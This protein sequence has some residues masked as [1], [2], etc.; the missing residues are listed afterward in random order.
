MIASYHSGARLAGGL[1]TI[2]NGSREV[3][4]HFL[5][6]STSQQDY[7]DSKRIEG[8]RCTVSLILD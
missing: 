2:P 6:C 1:A 7:Y 5:W 3:D 8:G 4:V